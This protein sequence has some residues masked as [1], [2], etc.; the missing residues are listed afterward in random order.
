LP[1]LLCHLLEEVAEVVVEID[2]NN[3]DRLISELQDVE[4]IAYLAGLAAQ[5]LRH[6]TRSSGQPVLLDW[7][8]NYPYARTTKRP[9]RLRHCILQTIAQLHAKFVGRTYTGVD[10]TGSIDN[11]AQ[12][13]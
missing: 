4:N 10:T 12:V 6:K 13:K 3:V 5:N 1:S 8:M 7:P 2:D 11:D 9:T